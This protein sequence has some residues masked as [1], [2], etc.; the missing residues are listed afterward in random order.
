MQQGRIRRHN[1]RIFFENIQPGKPRTPDESYSSSPDTD[2]DKDDDFDNL[3]KRGMKR[4]RLNA[5]ADRIV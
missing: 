1:S 3:S 4:R 2:S 5:I